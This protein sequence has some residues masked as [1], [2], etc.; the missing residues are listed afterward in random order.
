MVYA[1]RC[2]REGIDFNF[3]HTCKTK[4]KDK[5]SMKQELV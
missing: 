1:T 2:K 3:H 4:A 5:I